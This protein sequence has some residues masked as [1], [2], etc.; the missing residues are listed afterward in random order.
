[1]DQERD[2]SMFLVLDILK[3]ANVTYSKNY[4]K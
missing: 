1:M 2:F 4:I 3:I